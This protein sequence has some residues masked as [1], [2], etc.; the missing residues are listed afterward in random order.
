LAK[1]STCFLLEIGKR[2]EQRKIA[3]FV[4]GRLDAIVQ[5]LLHPFPD[6]IAPRPDDHAAPHAAFFGHV[7]FGNDSLIPGGKILF[8]GNGKGVLHG[9]GLALI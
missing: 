7:G 2:D 1:P 6:A 8:A 3:I 4:T 5:Q 9:S